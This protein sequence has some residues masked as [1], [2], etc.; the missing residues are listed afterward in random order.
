[1]SWW[2]FK[3][4]EQRSSGG[5]TDFR[6]AALLADVEGVSADAS[7]TAMVEAAAGLVGRAFATASVND[8]TFTAPLLNLIGRQLIRQGE[9][10]LA[11]GNE[12]RRVMLIP[13]G[14]WHITGGYDPRR[15]VYRVDLTGPTG[16]NTLHL[17]ADSVLHF[18]Y[19]C[20]P[21]QTWRG[22]SPLEYAA[23][24][25]KLSAATIR[26]LANEAQGPHGALM[27][28]PD[29]DGEAE[30]LADLKT[31]IAGLKGGLGFVE[32]MADS[33]KSGEK[34]PGD[35]KSVRLG[36]DPPPAQVKLQEQASREV[37][38]ACGLSPAL[39]DSGASATA[40]REAWRQALFGLIAP[41]AR[42]V[43]AEVRAKLRP[44]FALAF[45]EIRAADITGRAR[46]WRSLVGNEA[47]MPA[48]QAAEIVGFAP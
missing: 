20:D 9:I 36:A 18:Q 1:M 19:A 12:G 7:A 24:S 34:A 27:P 37:L 43:E 40:S 31:D 11:I 13:A 10:V 21:W 42:G 32:S 8:P 46:A 35:W 38:A 5:Y 28:L 26:A 22:R 33:W 39:F 17:G 48:D 25:G 41:L 45:D 44:E 4:T 29:V 14:T 15:W 6:L 16:Q 47:A 2:R 3:R 30:G 23:S